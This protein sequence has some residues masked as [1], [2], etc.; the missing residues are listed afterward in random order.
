MDGERVKRMERENK[1]GR[2]RVMS[3]KEEGL[4]ERGRGIDGERER[5]KV[6][7]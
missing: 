7:T 4:V 3:G 1:I 2:E 5:E 6:V